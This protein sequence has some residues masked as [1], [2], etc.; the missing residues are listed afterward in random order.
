MEIK[1]IFSL[2]YI[3]SFVFAFI[4]FIFFM[5]LD[6]NMSPT[7]L[8]IYKDII[9]YYQIPHKKEVISNIFTNYLYK[10]ENSVNKVVA[11]S[12]I[13]EMI[14]F[15]IGFL[16]MSVLDC[17][18]NIRKIIYNYFCHIIL[19]ASKIIVMKYLLKLRNYRIE[20]IKPVI[21][22]YIENEKYI[23]E[24]D[25]V[26]DKAAE[27]DKIFIIINLIICIIFFINIIITTI[28]IFIDNGY[29][30]NCDCTCNFP[31]RNYNNF[32]TSNNNNNNQINNVVVYNNNNTNNTDENI[33]RNISLN[34]NA[35]I[36]SNENINVNR[37][38]T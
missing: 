14:F 18:S 6:M 24:F 12:S 4:H 38:S 30:N 29:C 19:I 11:I 23:A 36:N 10:I 33:N 21:S 13:L 15:V 17:S 34:R 20:Y 22:E 25:K 5:L 37:T 28:L 9:K 1:K 35:I 7:Q 2:Y 32:S 16:I 3:L 8:K 31:R 26:N 27:T